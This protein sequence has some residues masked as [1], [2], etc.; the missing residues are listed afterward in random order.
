MVVLR[1]S[2]QDVLGE[3]PHVRRVE[4]DWHRRAALKIV[5]QQVSELQARKSVG[6]DG[7][8]AFIDTGNADAFLEP[9]SVV[10]T[11][12]VALLSDQELNLHDPHCKTSASYS[13]TDVSG[14]GNPSGERGSSSSVASASPY[15]QGSNLTDERAR[16]RTLFSGNENAP[17]GGFLVRQPD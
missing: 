16:S 3:A 1:T 15:L 11:E 9:A 6:I 17:S 12:N 8:V 10:L 4:L 2:R 5:G 7:S 14:D 13:E